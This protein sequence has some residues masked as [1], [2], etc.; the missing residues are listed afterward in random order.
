MAR[1]IRTARGDDDRPPGRYE[2]ELPEG[3]TAADWGLEKVRVQNPSIRSYLGCIRLLE[4]VLDSNYAIL[5]CSPERLLKI[6]RQVEE[7]GR[8]MRSELLPTLE[9]R[10][11]V[12]GLDVA[13]RHALDSFHE[14][15]ET[16]LTAMDRCEPPLRADQLP[17]LRKLLCLWIGKVYGFLRDTFGEIVA[18][19]PRS[20]HD[21]DYFLSK[22]FAQDIE[23]SEW[24]Y[25]SVYLEHEGDRPGSPRQVADPPFP[26][27]VDPLRSDPAA[28]ARVERSGSAL[29][30]PDRQ[31]PSRL[32]ELPL[33]RLVTDKA[34]N[35][36]YNV[37][38]HPP[39]G[40]LSRL[41]SENEILCRRVPPY[42]SAAPRQSCR[43]TVSGTDRQSQSLRATS[44]HSTGTRRPHGRRPPPPRRSQRLGAPRALRLSSVPTST[45]PRDLGAS[46]GAL[47]S[48]RPAPPL[49]PLPSRQTTR[50][51]LSHALAAPRSRI[52]TPD[53]PRTPTLLRLDAEPLQ[54]RFSA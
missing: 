7:V 21:A 50:Y 3:V 14:L 43:S 46:A 44:P 37:L 42:L 54:S 40:L 15:R 39:A 33:V 52:S 51:L 35:A 6:W 19:D 34:Q 24:L 9:L 11:V 38:G 22:R 47:S 5:H 2:V 1:T 41:A 8:L 36:P 28:A 25:S 16:V 29:P 27:A 17:E 26:N 12:P 32:V 13:R 4:E 53:K 30:D 45:P 10:S 49:I 48:P 23:E 20:R 31:N 18:S